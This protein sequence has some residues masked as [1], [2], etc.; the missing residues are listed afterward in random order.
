MVRTIAIRRAILMIKENF[1]PEN[2]L[3][4]GYF[5]EVRFDT[6]EENQL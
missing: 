5:T 6:S 3:F 4:K 1:M 2:A